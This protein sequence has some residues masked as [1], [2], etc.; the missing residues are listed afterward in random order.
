MA[1]MKVLGG[2]CRWPQVFFY[3]PWGEE[4]GELKNETALILA[5]LFFCHLF[6]VPLLSFSSFPLVIILKTKFTILYFFIWA[7]LGRKLPP[8]S[9]QK[10]PKTWGWVCSQL[11]RNQ[12]TTRSSCGKDCRRTWMTRRGDS[13]PCFLIALQFGTHYS[14]VFEKRAVPRLVMSRLRNVLWELP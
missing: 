12:E 9:R 7:W 8:S 3:V 11:P 2:T 14:T 4:V 6:D 5:S 1:G 13:I 10:L